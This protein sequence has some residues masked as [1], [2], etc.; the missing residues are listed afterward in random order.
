MVTVGLPTA[1]TQREDTAQPYDP[2]RNRT[3]THA[4]KT[5]NTLQTP[6]KSTQNSG[7]LQ[8]HHHGPRPLRLL[9]Q[10]VNKSA[11]SLGRTFESVLGRTWCVIVKLYLCRFP[12]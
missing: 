4:N 5:I 10:T 12:P 1:R 6:E 7:I 2:D 8:T 11:C 9:T 3:K